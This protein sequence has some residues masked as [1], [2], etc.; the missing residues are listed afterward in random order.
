M[1]GRV[2]VSQRSIEIVG[3]SPATAQLRA[4]IERVAPFASNVL[5]TG[6]SGTGKE[7]VARQIHAL[8]PRAAHPFVPVD[9]AAMTGELMSSQ[10]F[11]HVS[12][13][14]TGANC[15]ALGCFRAAHRGTIFLDEIGELD[16][17]LQSKL[18]RVLQELMVT[19]VGSHQGQ[20]VDVRVVAATNR[21][22]R[23]EVAAGRFR[24][25]LFYRL[26]VV[27]LQTT[28]LRDRPGDIPE[29]AESFLEQLAA[30]G[31]PRCQLSPGAMREL[32]A[33][34][35]PGNIRQLRNVLEQAVIESESAELGSG[36]IACLLEG[37]SA[38][39]DEAAPE[40]VAGQDSWLE[41]PPIVATVE[42]P[43]AAAWMTLAA[44]ERE[45]LQRTLEPTFYNRSAAA[46]LLGITRQALLRKMERH[47]IEIPDSTR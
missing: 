46:R 15:D 45:H 2:L 6:P 22:L 35:W 12:G 43:S 41:P 42:A 10:L 39:I 17:A 23:S 36:R 7:L 28:P 5:I 47:G 31:L 16:Y 27:H 38:D 25:D 19:P 37:P 20:P 44:L 8:S 24:E 1:A 13:A 40:E 34:T 33:F 11:G 3:H 9:C 26:H 18:L 14:F 4:Q 30:E 29:L 21:D 32:V